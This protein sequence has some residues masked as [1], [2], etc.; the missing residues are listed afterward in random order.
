MVCRQEGADPITVGLAAT[1]L[2]ACLG[3]LQ[4]VLSSTL[5]LNLPPCKKSLRELAEIENF[6]SYCM[7]KCIKSHSR[8][9]IKW[10]VW[11]EAAAAAA[12]DQFHI[13]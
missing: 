7:Q 12:S 6:C 4:Q 11:T 13:V 10:A 5:S 3:S 8:A 1:L 9:F 2:G